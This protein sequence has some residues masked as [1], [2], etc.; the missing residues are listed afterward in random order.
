MGLR[1]AMNR[2]LCRVLEDLLNDPGLVVPEDQGRPGEKLHPGRAKQMETIFGLLQ[3]RR[4]YYFPAGEEENGRAPLDEALGLLNSYSPGLVRMICRVG[5]RESFV[6]GEQD[7]KALA[8]VEVQSRQIQRVVNLVGPSVRETLQP[9]VLP[10]VLGQRLPV[11]YITMDGTGVPMV[12]EELKGR[13]GKQE[14]GSAKTCEIK[15]GCTFTQTKTDEE[16]LPVRDYK[17][18]SYLVSFDQAADFG[19]QLRQEALRRGMGRADLTVVISDGASGLR[20]IA[21]D[22][23]SFAVHILDM[24]HALVH[25]SALAGVLHGKDC[26][27][28]KTAEIRWKHWLEEDKVQIVLDEVNPLAKKL[29]GSRRE[30]ALENIGYVENNKD[31]M[32]YGTYRKQGLFYGSGVVEAGCKTIIGQRLK[33]SGM[34]W[35]KPGALN[36]AILRCALLDDRFENYWNQRN[37]TDQFSIK[38]VA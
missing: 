37:K 25:L 5:A 38:A 27:E 2:D 6:A 4:N 7:L 20:K 3:L 18:T 13:A 23:F 35:T 31:R 32:L 12:A 16:D 36:V 33:N 8:G 19:V 10:E 15:V 28:A 22:K 21:E 30:E 34:F 29:R 11:F 24:Y 9:K 14:D 17:S 26:A 1:A